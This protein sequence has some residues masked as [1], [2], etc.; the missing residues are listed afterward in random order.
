MY[1]DFFHLVQS[2]LISGASV[3]VQLVKNLPANAGDLG[4]VPGSGR[5]PG[6]GHGNLLR[7]SCLKNPMDRKQSRLQSMGT[8]SWTQLND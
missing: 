1:C 6:G 3:V 2:M 7:Y 5:Y 8:Q 4:L